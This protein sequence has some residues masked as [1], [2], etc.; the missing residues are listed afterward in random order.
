MGAFGS[1][2]LTRLKAKRSRFSGQCNQAGN[3]HRLQSI[4]LARVAKVVLGTIM[5]QH[6]G[7]VCLAA[8]V[9]LTQTESLS[10]VDSF[11]FDINLV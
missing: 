2:D 9:G 5:V 7:I 11:A 4:V 10:F 1:Q 8:D 6:G 3:S